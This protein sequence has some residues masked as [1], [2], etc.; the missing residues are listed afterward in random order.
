[1]KRKR[2][3]NYTWIHG[4]NKFGKEKELENT[5]K[6]RLTHEYMEETNLKKEKEL[7]NTVKEQL[8][9]RNKEDIEQKEFIHRGNRYEECQTQ[10]N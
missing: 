6:K 10:I 3:G 7:E 1:M 9:V 5:V 2:V 4:G 8:I